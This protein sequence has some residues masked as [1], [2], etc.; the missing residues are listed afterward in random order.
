MRLQVL[1]ESHARER[2]DR[3]AEPPLGEIL[4]A[5]EIRRK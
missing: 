4:S 2:L 1:V 3:D 5:P